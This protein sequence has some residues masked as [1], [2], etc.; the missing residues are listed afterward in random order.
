MEQITNDD[1]E[2][3]TLKTDIGLNKTMWKYKCTK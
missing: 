3:L 2:K 1:I